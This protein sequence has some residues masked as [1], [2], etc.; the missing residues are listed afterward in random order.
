MKKYIF[1]AF[2]LVTV[3]LLAVVSLQYKNRTEALVAVV[4]S[5][6]TAISFEDPVVVTSIKV[7]P[8]QLVSSGDTLITLIR[9]D[10]DLDIEQKKNEL[11]SVKSQI[12][13]LEK[14]Y[15]SKIEL[16]KLERVGKEN[17]LKAEINELKTKQNQ[18]SLIRMKLGQNTIA[19]TDSLRTIELSAAKLELDNIQEYFSKEIQ[20]EK[21][22]Q[23]SDLAFKTRNL[24]IVTKELLALLD[25]QDQLVRVSK[26]NG[27]VGVVNVQLDELVPP[28]KSLITL[29][30]ANPSIIKAFHNE[31]L[32]VAVKPGDSVKVV[33]ENRSYSI[34][35]IVQE[36]GARITN[37]PNKIQPAVGSPLSYGQEIFI[38]IPINNKFLNGEKVFVYPNHVYED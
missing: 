17:R 33:S 31:Q 10:L 24:S 21:V 38:R 12:D 14:N 4:A 26:I 22:L 29:Y 9:P 11:E 25:Q 35:G 19:Y 2:W 3:V 36:L 27:I 13:Q 6:E 34:Y 7:V 28:Y 8:G 20:R 37:Y 5:Q 23:Q 1:I 18:Q 30:E 16:L 32:E 15:L